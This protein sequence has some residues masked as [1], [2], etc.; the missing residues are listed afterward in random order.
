MKLLHKLAI[1]GLL[2]GGPVW[3]KHWHEDTDD[4]NWHRQHYHDEET[5]ERK[6]SKD[7]YFDPHDVRLISQYY[8]P[9]YRPLPRGLE[10]KFRRKATLPS[11]WETRLDLLPAALEPAESRRGIIDGF[12][13]VYSPQ[14][15]VILDSV[16][17]FGGQ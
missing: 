9:R 12:A 5:E 13:V 1:S 7:C 3:G 6:R 14:T 17:L 16:A 4:R 10:N 8:A 11:G 2:L 15:A